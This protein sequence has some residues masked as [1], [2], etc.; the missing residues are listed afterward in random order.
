MYGTVHPKPRCR[1]A[2]W[3][4]TIK[5]MR[6]RAE[7][8]CRLAERSLALASKSVNVSGGLIIL[9]VEDEI[10]LRG[11]IAQYL[12]DRGCVVLEADSAEQ[13]SAI[14]RSGQQVDVL[15]T[16]IN[17]NGTGNGFDVAEVFRA[18][19]P[20]VGVVYVSGNFVDRNRCVRDSLFFDKPYL[21][22]EILQACQILGKRQAF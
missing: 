12:Q 16:D 11:M 10:L 22:A 9:M 17:L 8:S 1:I 7:P 4:E 5:G 6:A 3:R 21:D 19:Q 15:V 18:A 2:P 20:D 13:A 14:C